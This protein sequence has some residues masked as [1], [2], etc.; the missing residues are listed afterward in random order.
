VNYSEQEIERIVADTQKA[1]DEG[2]YRLATEKEKLCLRVAGLEN[3]VR[4]YQ[5]IIEK[6]FGSDADNEPETALAV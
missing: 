5:T 1:V 4:S 6:T 2:R 3:I